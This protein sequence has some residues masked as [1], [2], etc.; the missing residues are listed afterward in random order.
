MRT[1]F[2]S[3]LCSMDEEIKKQ[4]E[5]KRITIAP[6]FPELRDFDFLLRNKFET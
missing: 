1:T 2:V 3:I 6:V 5:K 4:I